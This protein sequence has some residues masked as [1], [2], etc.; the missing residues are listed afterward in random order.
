MA[1][2]VLPMITSEL[3]RRAS[4]STCP[5]AGVNQADAPGCRPQEQ[6]HDHFGRL[7]PVIRSCRD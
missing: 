3:I 5:P 4:S 6:A 7:R 1:S 2:L